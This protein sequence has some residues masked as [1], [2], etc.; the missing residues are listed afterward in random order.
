MYLNL[1]LHM[2]QTY[3]KENK[4]QDK[5]RRPFLCLGY[6]TRHQRGVLINYVDS[7]YRSFSVE[8]TPP[9]VKNLVSKNPSAE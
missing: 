6:R 5:T 8:T 9:F 7:A 1:L 2:L 3:L 4:T